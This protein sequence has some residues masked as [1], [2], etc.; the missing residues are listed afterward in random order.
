MMLTPNNGKLV[1]STGNN[2]QCTAHNKEVMIPRP[3]QF[4][5]KFII[6]GK[7]NIFAIMLQVLTNQDNQLFY[8][9]HGST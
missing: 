2:A 4:T 8:P 1:S 3:S 6:V 5:F 7:G 9:L